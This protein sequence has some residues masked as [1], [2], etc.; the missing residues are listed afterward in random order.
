MPAT[1]RSVFTNLGIAMDDVALGALA[2]ERARERGLGR[3]VD[4]P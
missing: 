4:F 1:G 3:T 2:Y